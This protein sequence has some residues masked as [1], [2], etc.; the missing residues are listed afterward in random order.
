MSLKSF[1]YL[2]ENQHITDFFDWENQNPSEILCPKC[3]E[4]AE[5]VWLKAPG[6]NPDNLWMGVNTEIGYVTSKSQLRDIMTARGERFHEPGVEKDAANVLKNQKIVDRAI[7]K[8][9]IAEVWKDVEKPAH[10]LKPKPRT[11]L[12]E[13]PNK[14]AE[15]KMLDEKEAKVYG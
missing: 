11:D 6:I 3:G 9:K 1:D 2:C 4:I 10:K 14:P 8:A 5:K 12:N 13:N 7:R 15:I